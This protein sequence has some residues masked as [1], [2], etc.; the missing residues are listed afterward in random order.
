[1]NDGSTWQRSQKSLIII[2]SVCIILLFNCYYLFNLAEQLFLMFGQVA[3][4]GDIMLL[5]DRQICLFPCKQES[6]CLSNGLGSFWVSGFTFSFTLPFSVS[7]GFFTTQYGGVEAWA[8]HGYIN[9]FP[10]VWIQ[11]RLEWQRWCTDR[12]AGPPFA[13]GAPW[14]RNSG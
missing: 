3:R 12:P 11:D 5:S 8:E 10:N 13:P 9:H 4:N 1:M 2:K 14:P 7:N 6:L